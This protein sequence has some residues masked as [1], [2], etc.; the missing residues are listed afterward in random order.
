MLTT[1]QI[2]AIRDQFKPDDMPSRATVQ[3]IAELLAASAPTPSAPT[4]P[5]QENAF[6]KTESEHA[7]A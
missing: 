7:D 6:A 5:A 3:R 1:D 2:D 4:A